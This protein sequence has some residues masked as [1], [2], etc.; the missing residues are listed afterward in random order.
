MERKL[1]VDDINYSNDCK[2]KIFLRL[3]RNA[4][5]KKHK[6]FIKSEFLL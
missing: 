5:V 2:F 6:N 4:V 1:N 3:Y